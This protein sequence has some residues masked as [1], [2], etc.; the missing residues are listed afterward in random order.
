MISLCYDP[1]E[2]PLYRG[3]FAD[4]WKGQHQGGEVAA[5]VLRVCVVDDPGQIRKVG[6]WS[7]DRPVCIRMTDRV[8]QGFC[9][10]VVGWKGLRHPNV[11]SLLGVTMI[12]NQFVMVSEWMVNGDINGFVKNHAG[13]NRLELVCF[14]FAAHTL[15][16]R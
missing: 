2:K 6:S 5:K 3:E 9:K 13:V 1:A 14:L 15:V 12:E 7:W 16:R 8:S 10:E 4:V 11:L